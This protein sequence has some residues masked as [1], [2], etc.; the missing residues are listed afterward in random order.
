[1]YLR[2][3]FKIS[4]LHKTVCSQMKIFYKEILQSKINVFIHYLMNKYSF[5]QKD[6][7][8][9]NVSKNNSTL[10]FII[11]MLGKCQ[12]NQYGYII[13]N[14][15]EDK[16]LIEIDIQILFLNCLKVAVE[17]E[18]QERFVDFFCTTFSRII[19]TIDYLNKLRHSTVIVCIQILSLYKYACLFAIHQY[20]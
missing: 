14:V 8:I 12:S 17:S 10:F 6:F 9:Q 11:A 20:V 7:N 1:M 16:W 13:T 19:S 5:F 2:Y 3:S 4:Y 15:L 18:V